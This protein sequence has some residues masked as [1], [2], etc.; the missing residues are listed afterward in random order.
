[1]CNRFIYRNLSK[2]ST[3]MDLV[4]SIIKA[5]G[6]LDLLKRHGKLSYAEMLKKTELPKS[7][8]FKILSTLESE[9]LVCKDLESGHYHLGVRLIEWGSGARSQLEIRKIAR[10]F[11]KTLS[12]SQDCTVHLSV[13]TH[14]KVLP[15]ESFESGSSYW[16]TFSFPGG[17]GIP[18]P[19]H[20]TGAGKAILAYLST[21]EI[22]S[23]IRRK[24]LEKFTKTTISDPDRLR[25]DLEEIRRRGYATTFGEHDDMVRSVAAPIFDHEGQVIASISAL[26]PASRFTVE[27]IPELAKL[28]VSAAREISHLFGFDP[29][30]EKAC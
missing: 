23:I 7:T 29:E 13:M 25:A 1:M 15:I 9:E 14:D 11:I 8:L 30:T 4:N 5:V 6:I 20:A 28:V 21:E 3:I 19:L 27:R 2:A 24:G 16:H 26:G 18:A 10:P 17:V 12:D 22:E